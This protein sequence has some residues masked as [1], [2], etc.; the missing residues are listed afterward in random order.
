[1]RRTIEA[2][3]AASGSDIWAVTQFGGDILHYNGSTWKVAHRLS[4]PGQLT[5]IT[6]FSTTNVLVFGSGGFTGGL[7]TWHYNGRR[8]QQ[9]TGTA[10]GISRASALSPASIWAI[11][12]TSSPAT[13]IVHYNGTSWQRVKATA[14]TGLQFNDILAQSRTS[15]WA[16]PSRQA[17]GFTAYLVHYNGSGWS[18]TKLPW[19]VDLG[20]LARD[21]HGGFWLSAADSS[22]RS[23]I[24]H[25]SPAG[26]WSR[27]LIGS[28][29]TDLADPVLIPGT[30]SLWGAGLVKAA[31]GANAAIWV[32]GQIP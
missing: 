28:P 15:I 16:T 12:A 24:V 5:G 23:W 2:A 9:V 17:S 8:W 10:S 27:T 20:R 31:T 7:G 13:A 25:R 4:G 22:A 18:R 3:S 30:T 14:L 19:A 26:L 11:G 29:P 6:A 21:G 32:H 1:L